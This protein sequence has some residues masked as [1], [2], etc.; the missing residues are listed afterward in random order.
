LSLVTNTILLGA[1]FY[2]I[3]LL[4]GL[5]LRLF[6]KDPMTLRSDPEALTYWVPVT[7]QSTPENSSDMF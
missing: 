1:L 2:T 3:V 6:G 7:R 4:T 5:M